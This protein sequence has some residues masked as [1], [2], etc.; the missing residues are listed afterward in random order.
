MRPRYLG[1]FALLTGSVL[2]QSPKVPASASRNGTGVEF[3][4]IA[5]GE[6]TMGCSEG[7]EQ[8]DADEKPAH[9]VQITKGFEMGKYESAMS[10]F[11]PFASRWRHDSPW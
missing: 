11:A 7:D 3:V 10:A 4:R 8:C 2:A 9:R 6:F 1:V 5:P